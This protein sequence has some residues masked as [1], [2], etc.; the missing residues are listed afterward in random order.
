[1]K[2]RTIKGVDDETWKIMKEMARQERLKMGLLLKEMAKEYKGKPSTVWNK[3]LNA[4]PIL[5]ADEARDMEK[6]VSKI[7]HE[8]GFRI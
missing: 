5:T 2:V 3:I 6:I 4:K 1:M 8:H 7:R